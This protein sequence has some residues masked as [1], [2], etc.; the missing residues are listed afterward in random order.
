MS[1]LNSR[2]TF[3]AREMLLRTRKGTWMSF[4]MFFRFSCRCIPT[5]G[6][7]MILYP[8]AGTFSISILPVAPTKRISVSG[9]SSFSLFAMEMAGKMCP[10]VPPPLMMARIGL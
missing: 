3:R 6:R 10:P 7:P 4:T 5:I 2:I 1:G 9:L 8:A